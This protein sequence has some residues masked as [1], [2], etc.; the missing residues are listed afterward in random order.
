MPGPDR[1]ATA[2][3]SST[4]LIG[5]ALRGWAAGPVG[6]RSVTPCLAGGGLAGVGVR[7][8]A[9]R[10][11]RA[12]TSPR[13][14]RRVA[15]LTESV[16]GRRCVPEDVPLRNFATRQPNRPPQQRRSPALQ[17]L[18]AARP[19]MSLKRRLAYPISVRSTI[20]GGGRA[21]VLAEIKDMIGR[22]LADL[23]GCGQTHHGILPVKDVARRARPRLFQR[24]GKT[25]AKK[26][27][28]TP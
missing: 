16:P 20:R 12:A 19:S 22:V 11:R 23:Q 28:G 5:P 27:D 15:K 3:L 10:R 14:L 25:I 6:S 1:G 26:T 4:S 2:T 17:A 18:L 9:L 8:T 24:R 13:G 21:C 7:S